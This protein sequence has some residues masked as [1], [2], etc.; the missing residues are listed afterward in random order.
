MG[1]GKITVEDTNGDVYEYDKVTSV[2]VKERG[3]II[4]SIQ[5]E[6]TTEI[7]EIFNVM[8][9]DYMKPI[10][11]YGHTGPTGYTGLINYTSDRVD[12]EDRP[13]I[14]PEEKFF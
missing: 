4:I 12:C 10:Q 3:W 6:K 8:Y 7:V 9:Y 13:T 1:I 2:T 11:E 5:N 14:Q